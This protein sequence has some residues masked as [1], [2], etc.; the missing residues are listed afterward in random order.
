[1]TSRPATHATFG[2]WSKIQ[3]IRQPTAFQIVRNWEQAD[4]A[5][6]TALGRLPTGSFPVHNRPVGYQ[7]TARV[8]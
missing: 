5:Q 7:A 1:M 2:S 4:A 8:D 3:S 6:M